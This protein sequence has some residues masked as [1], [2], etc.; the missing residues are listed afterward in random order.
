MK[1]ILGIA[2]RW[3]L[4]LSFVCVLLSICKLGFN[5]RIIRA[6]SE[7]SFWKSKGNIVDVIVFACLIG[8]VIYVSVSPAKSDDVM[9]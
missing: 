6:N 5:G 2:I 1:S 7:S 8:I 9:L 4:K 3:H